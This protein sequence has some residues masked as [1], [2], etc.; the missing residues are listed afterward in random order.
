MDGEF[1]AAEPGNKLVLTAG[2]IV[3]FV[4]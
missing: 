2:P 1:F 3:E 4:R